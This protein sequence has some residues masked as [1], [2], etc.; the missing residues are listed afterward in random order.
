M[1][2]VNSDILIDI[3]EEP[4]LDIDDH[5][6]DKLNADLEKIR[7]ASKG[8]NR[9]ITSGSNS[10]ISMSANNS[11]S[12]T[13]NSRG[14]RRLTFREVR[15]SIH[16]Y[17]DASHKYT[18]EF[19]L[20]TTYLKYQKQLYTQSASV[21]GYKMRIL[22]SPAII[23]GISITV[24]SPLLMHYS[25]SGAVISGVNSFVLGLFFIV[26]YFGFFP[27]IA[28]YMQIAKQFEKLEN[29]SESLANQYGF[30]DKSEDKTEYVIMHLR[31]IEKKYMDLKEIMVMDIPVELRRMYPIGYNIQVFS[32][33]KR[34]ETNKKSLIVRLK[35]VKNEIRYIER[36][37]EEDGL[38]D[39][40][41]TRMEFLY[42]TKEMLK[43]QIMHYYNAYGSMEDILVKEYRRS[44][45]F[46][47]YK[48]WDDNPVVKEY[49]ESIFEDD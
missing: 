27:A 14:M 32:F 20:L 18:T 11:D 5:Y 28:F 26:Y 41:K 23:G 48:K 13:D 45:F 16:K 24:F 10:P 21:S 8:L 22:L 37:T 9:F 7:L 19:D 3:S 1:H 40:Y 42:E 31:S 38:G 49:C 30:L 44:S 29:I 43:M 39:K 47:T 34:I 6:T 15:D 12:E 2:T 33:V 46:T 36:K 35:D 17:F 25:S 4:V